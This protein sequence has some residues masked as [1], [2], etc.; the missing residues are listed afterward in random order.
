MNLKK[1]SE[2]NI[3]VFGNT[4]FRGE[5]PLEMSEQVS[6]LAML[7]K[8]Y[9]ELA[10]IA[11]HIRNEGKR[12]IKQ[13]HQYKVEGLNTGACDIVIPCSPAILIELKRRDHTLSKISDEQIIYIKRS[14]KLGAFACVA[15]GAIGAME[16]IKQWHTRNKK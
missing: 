1:L 8:T 2:H 10:Q 16:A 9:P 14:E 15:V 11:V 7:R 13:G 6:F 12:S 4:D 3:K 5:C